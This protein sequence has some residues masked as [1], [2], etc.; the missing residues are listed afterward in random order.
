MHRVGLVAGAQTDNDGLRP[1]G[2]LQRDSDAV[3][4]R[5]QQV[6]SARAI[7][8]VEEKLTVSA[9]SDAADRA[10]GLGQGPVL[11]PWRG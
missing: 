4:H 1:V 9:N 2:R 6:P 10:L 11:E 8:N 3:P 7:L 5:L